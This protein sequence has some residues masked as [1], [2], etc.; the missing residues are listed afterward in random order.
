MAINLRLQSALLGIALF[1]GTSAHAGEQTEVRVYSN[2]LPSAHALADMLFPRARKTRS[3]V[4]AF[5]AQPVSPQAV[6][7]PIQFDL[8]SAAIRPESQ[9]DLDKIGEMLNLEQ[10]TGHGLRIEGHTDST[11]PDDYNDALSTRRA[12]AVANYLVRTHG[13]DPNRLALE[14]HGEARPLPG[15][16]GTDPVN[17]RV[18]FHPVD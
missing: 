10:L 9:A 8:D 17:R 7:A 18:E 3:I 15:Y 12:L 5:G 11:G 16:S 2:G 14:G 4:T 13:I 6:S 1:V